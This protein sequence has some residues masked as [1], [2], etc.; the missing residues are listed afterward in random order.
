M[1]HSVK[2]G[3]WYAVNAGSMVVAV[4]FNETDNCKIYVWAICRQL[5]P[6]LT[7]EE[8]LYGWFQQ[9]LSTAHTAH[10]YLCRLC[11]VSSG[12]GL[13]AVIFGQH[14]QL[15]LILMLF[16]SGGCLNNKVYNSN[17]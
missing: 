17:P 15:I 2:A 6:E 3:V 10:I 13:S 4:S 1:L 12:I 8:R 9:D 11:P 16:F 5:F 14:I 7:E